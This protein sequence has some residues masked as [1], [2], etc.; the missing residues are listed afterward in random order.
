MSGP[1]QFVRCVFR[2]TDLRSFTYHNDAEPVA[3]GDVV[4]VPNKD[5]I[6][7]KKVF[8]VGLTDEKPSFPTK[9]IIGPH[10]EDAEPKAPAPA[11]IPNLI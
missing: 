5:G 7:W 4:R 1:R 3:V 11:E 2:E 6:G 10:V 9:S 8:V